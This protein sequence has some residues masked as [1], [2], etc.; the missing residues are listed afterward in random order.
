MWGTVL[1]A[2]AM[3]ESKMAS[4]LAER[5]DGRQIMKLINNSFD[6]ELSRWS[7]RFYKRYYGNQPRLR[8]SPWRSGI[9]IEFWKTSH[10]YLGKEREVVV[11]WMFQVKKAKCAQSL[12]NEGAWWMRGGGRRPGKWRSMVGE[13]SR[14]K[15]WKVQWRR[16]KR[17]EP[18]GMGIGGHI[19]HFID[20]LLLLF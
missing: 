13:R 5:A 16:R 20:L 3:A 8:R 15:A 4:A 14:E 10:N 18:G 1:S 19:E 17:A 6:Q 11:E 12:G 2:G 7:I 9:W